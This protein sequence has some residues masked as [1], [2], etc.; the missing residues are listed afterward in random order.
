MANMTS[1]D[2][3]Q[4]ERAD[5]GAPDRSMRV[6][7]RR[8]VIIFTSLALVILAAL[9]YTV[10]W[11]INGWPQALVLGVIVVTAIGLMIAVSPNRRG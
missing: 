10:A 8:P 2:R 9:A 6:S 3:A 1:S 7:N 11:G 5:L 4:Y